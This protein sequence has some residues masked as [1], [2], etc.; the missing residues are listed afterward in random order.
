MLLDE[1]ATRIGTLGLSGYTITTGHRP[2]TPDK[3]VTIYET[4]GA[5]AEL[6]F[7]VAG[8]QFEHPT[9]QVVVRAAANDYETARNAM[10][11]IYVDLPKVQGTT[12]S[13]TTYHLIIPAQA[14]F[15]LE[16]DVQRRPVLVVNFAITKVP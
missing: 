16:R 1:I 4:G 2:D 10:Q 5:A 12:L 13:G 15:L 6:G 3:V 11:L 9:I 14:P 7:G 8:I